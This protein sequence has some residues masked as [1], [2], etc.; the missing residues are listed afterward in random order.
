LF[1]GKIIMQH[2]RLSVRRRALFGLLLCSAAGTQAQ[3]G[4]PNKSIQVIVP[5]QAGSA[6]DVATRVVLA[7]VG[8]NMKT[9]F[10]IDNQAG[11]SGL[12]GAEKVSRAAPDG[13]T[14]GGI[15]DSV[16]NYA[17]NLAPKVSF[18]P[19]SDFEPISQMVRISWVLVANTDFPAKNLPDLVSRARAQPMKIDYASGGNGSPQHI[20]MEL[21]A[22]ANK[23]QMNHVPYKGATQA[24]VDVAGGQVPIMFSAVSVVL[25]LV[26]EGKLRALAQPNDNRSD[27]LPDVPTFAEAGVT[28]FSFSTWL[29]LYAPRGTPRPIVDRLNAEVRKAISDPAVRERLVGLGL[30]PVTSTP[31]QLGEIT[32]AGY[33]RVGKAIRDANIRTQ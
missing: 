24:M 7:K 14:L 8:E 25:P 20:S 29:G 3:S 9:S 23:L 26:R 11:V 17:V 5:L 15:T 28:S 12:L 4:Y 13:Y 2:S 1:K 6:A 30:E 21:F 27:L 32:K 10:V 16:L 31:L 33:E 18:D 22:R 19:L